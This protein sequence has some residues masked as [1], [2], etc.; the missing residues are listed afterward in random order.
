MSQDLS[1]EKVSSYIKRTEEALKKIKIIAPEN[2]HLIKIANDF[3]GMARSYFSDADYFFKKG[4]LVN[5]FAAIN[6]AH[7]WIDAGARLGL[8]DVGN[9]HA[10]FTLAN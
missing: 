4:D 6:Y 9:D 2:S 10:L 7:G 8:F 3:L 5:A 1:E